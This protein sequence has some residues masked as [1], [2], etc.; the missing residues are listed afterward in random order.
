MP[1]RA[2]PSTHFI[3]QRYLPRTSPFRR[4]AGYFGAPQ[5]RLTNTEIPILYASL[6]SPLLAIAR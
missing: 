4:Y 5:N 3:F 6:I 1:L 2:L